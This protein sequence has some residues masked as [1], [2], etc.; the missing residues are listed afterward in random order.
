MS[1]QI[2]LRRATAAAWTTANPILAE[3]EPGFETDTG[4]IK[5]GDGTSDWTSL[6]YF[7]NGTSAVQSVNGQTGTVVITKS[8]LSLGNVDNTSDA[9]KPVSTAQA[10]ADA[11]V[12]AYAIQRANHTGTQAASTISDFSAAA[13]ARVSSGVA[14]HV[15][16]PDPHPQ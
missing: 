14:T 1:Q 13:D 5:Y 9:N 4:F 2:Q 12:Q 3:G 15:A 7:D 8:D 11:A 6:P 10:A 16:A